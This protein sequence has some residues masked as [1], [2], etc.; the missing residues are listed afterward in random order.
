MAN[1]SLLIAESSPMRR[2]QELIFP[3]AIIG[4]V[5]VILVPLP[6]A[7]MD[8]LLASNI[9]IAVLVL[10]TTIYIRNPLELCISASFLLATTMGWLCFNVATTR[11]IMTH[12][13]TKGMTV[14]GEVV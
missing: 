6:P 3:L 14:A 1:G 11:L 5:L 12:A 2:I 9:S 13:A 8:L 7:L 4:S 10:L